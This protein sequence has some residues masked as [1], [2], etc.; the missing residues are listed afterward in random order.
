MSCSS[1]GR[2]E[3]DTTEL[4]WY[5]NFY[6][7]VNLYTVTVLG[8][9][10]FCSFLFCLFGLTLA[11]VCTDLLEFNSWDLWHNVKIR[12]TININLYETVNL[13]IEDIMEQLKDR[14][15]QNNMNQFLCSRR[16]QLWSWSTDQ[17]KSNFPL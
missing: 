7:S 1:W 9:M 12:Q 6:I 17:F 3:L 5:L 16:H 14:R 2:K 8:N 15:H 10:L 4:N 11:Q 13:R